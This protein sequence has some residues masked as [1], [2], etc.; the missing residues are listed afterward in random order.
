MAILAA[1]G[2]GFPLTQA[3]IARL[4]R[5]GAI[6]V[7]GVT[8]GLLARDV[9][10]LVMGTHRRLEPGPAAMLWAETASAAVA[11]GAGLLLLRDPAVADA[12]RRGWSAPRRELVRRIAIGTLFGL[13]TMRFRIFLAPG[14][15]LLE[16]ESTAPTPGTGPGV[17][18]G[19]SGADQAD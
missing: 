1:S 7:A 18:A 9:A 16:P 17:G 4:G 13:H 6:L 8:G 5:P 19:S 10:L 3:V 12:R 14:S 15:G 11:T 2:S